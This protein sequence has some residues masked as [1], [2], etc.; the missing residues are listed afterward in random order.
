[1]PLGHS[2]PLQD[3]PWWL[4]LADGWRQL[5]PVWRAPLRSAA[6][7]IDLDA[8]S[9]ALLADRLAVQGV[10]HVAGQPFLE[11]GE[12]GCAIDT[13]VHVAGDLARAGSWAALAELSQQLACSSSAARRALETAEA[14]G[15]RLRRRWWRR[16]SIFRRRRSAKLAPHAAAMAGRA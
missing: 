4:E 14:D 6:G 8:G 2:R 7:G 3:E 15:R 11:A 12:V 5:S 10:G 9:L 1:T 16:H 13:A